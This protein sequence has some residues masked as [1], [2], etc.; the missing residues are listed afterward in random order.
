MKI[1]KNPVII[2]IFYVAI[3]FFEKKMKKDIRKCIDKSKKCGI[4][5]IRK[6]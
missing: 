6:K 3:I 5:K 2:A 1:Y 4:F